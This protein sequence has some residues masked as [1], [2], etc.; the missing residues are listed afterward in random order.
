MIML[1]YIIFVIHTVTLLLMHNVF[2]FSDAVDDK[3]N[4]HFFMNNFAVANSI[5]H[6]T[7]G[8]RLSKF[9]WELLSK[10]H[11]EKINKRNFCSNYFKE[12]QS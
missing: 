2:F 6:N 4:N 9:Y 1:Y 12:Y 3:K 7:F 8:R 10:L 11:K 5:H